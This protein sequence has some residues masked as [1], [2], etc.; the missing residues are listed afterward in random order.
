[1]SLFCLV[2]G[3]LQL[4]LKNCFH[5][6]WQSRVSVCDL[7]QHFFLYIWAELMKAQPQN[8]I[9]V[10]YLCICNV[11]PRNRMHKNA[12]HFL[13]FD[14]VSE[15]VQGNIG[16]QSATLE[17]CWLKRSFSFPL[18]ASE[19]VAQS[20]RIVSVKVQCSPWNVFSHQRNWLSGTI[21]VTTPHW[22][23]MIK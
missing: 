23:M 15:S 13:C 16:H 12:R 5:C 10:S 4:I 14:L 9:S 8:I 17:F 19:W 20:R 18:P 3:S 6:H 7:F 21:D 1:M 22:D 11:L 2:Q